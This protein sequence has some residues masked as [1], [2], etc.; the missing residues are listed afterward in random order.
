MD[1]RRVKARDVD[2]VP[3][4]I[5][6]SDI[7]SKGTLWRVGVGGASTNILMERRQPSPSRNILTDTGCWKIGIYSSC[8]LLIWRW[9]QVFLC[10]KISLALPNC[11]Y[12]YWG[13]KSDACAFSPATENVRKLGKIS[14]FKMNII[15]WNSAA[16][17]PPWPSLATGAI[18]SG[19][20]LIDYYSFS[21]FSCKDTAQQMRCETFLS[22]RA[23]NWEGIQTPRKSSKILS[24]SWG[25][26]FFFFRGRWWTEDISEC[27]GKVR[28]R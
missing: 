19:L 27:T 17:Q 14:R 26:F 24:S 12:T 3:F 9:I 6:I 16:L 1:I 4:I 18:C 8:F 5:M 23:E 21:C 10:R 13:E 15:T 25:F 22:R 28:R 2:W 7:G 11:N 20:G